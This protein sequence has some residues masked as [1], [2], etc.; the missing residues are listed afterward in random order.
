ME[1]EE[2]PDEWADASETGV[3]MPLI[4]SFQETDWSWW[5]WTVVLPCPIPSGLWVIGG[6]GSLSTG[7]P[8]GRGS[9]Y[10]GLM[11]SQAPSKILHQGSSWAAGGPRPEKGDTRSRTEIP[12]VGAPAGHIGPW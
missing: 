3:M 8:S 11:Y 7:S 5:F 12:H 9:G 1:G 6:V 4:C 2:W 10:L